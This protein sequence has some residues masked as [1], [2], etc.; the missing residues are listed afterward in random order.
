MDLSVA[1]KAIEKLYVDKCDVYWYVETIDPDTHITSMKDK[2]VYMNISCKLSYKTITTSSNSVAPQVSTVVKLMIPVTGPS[3][4]F[5]T[6]QPG[7]K[8]VVRRRNKTLTFKSSGE[9]AIFLN[10][11]EIMLEQWE[12]YA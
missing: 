8:I 11:Q 6:V 1:R 4:G 12:D 2:M 7:S 3:G 9:P 10:H 5:Y